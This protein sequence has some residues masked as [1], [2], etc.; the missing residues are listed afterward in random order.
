MQMRST[1]RCD[2]LRFHSGS[3]GF[4]LVE[5]A[6]VVVI[7]ALLLGAILTPLATQ[8]Q[9]RKNNETE[10]A[11]REIKEALI[12]FAIS[13]GRLPCP[14]TDGDGIENPPPPKPLPPAPPSICTSTVG[15]LPWI[16]LGTMPTDAWGRIYRYQVSNEF[17]SYVQTGQ[18]SGPLQLDLDDGGLLPPPDL[19]TVITRGDDPGTSPAIEGKF[20]INMTTSA[21][22][23]VVSLG[24]NGF[25]GSPLS[26]PALLAPIGGDEQ[27]NLD[28]N[29]Q[30]V[31][32]SHTLEQ[33]GCGDDTNEATP[34][35]EYDDLIIWISPSE[36]LNRLVQA[37]RLP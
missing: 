33:T 24:N 1:H 28:N 7:V 10:R 3:G 29:S 25:G 16:T 21:P 35:C 12:G 20:E 6:V 26:G 2:G 36:L 9:A 14:D 31:L 22:A 34:L 37:G 5:L 17:A 23:V 4:T 19:I 27:D 30:Y 8:F 15:S 11:L 32:R 13:H 18:P